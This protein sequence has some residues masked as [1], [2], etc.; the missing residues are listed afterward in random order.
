MDSAGELFVV[1]RAEIAGNHHADA[2]GSPRKEADEQENER[3]RRADRAHCVVGN[4][5]SD[6][7]GIDGIVK[8]LKQL[9]EEHRDR[10]AQDHAA[11][12]ARG[13]I[14]RLPSGEFHEFFPF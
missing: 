3:A 10:K 4:H 9:A 2:H 11:R 6:R 5:M 14:Q 12:V 13:H 1:S 8:L 7:Q